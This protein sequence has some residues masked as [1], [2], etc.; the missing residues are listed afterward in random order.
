MTTPPVSPLA[1]AAGI[2][3]VTTGLVQAEI[4]RLESAFRARLCDDRPLP[5]C[6]AKAYRTLIEKRR[7]QLLAMQR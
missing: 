7:A 2:Q 6:I 4:C 5:D 3:H 1:N